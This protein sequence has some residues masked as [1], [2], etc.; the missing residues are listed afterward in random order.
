MVSCQIVT[1]SSLK[2]GT[3]RSSYDGII[4]RERRLKA[5]LLS[6]PEDQHAESKKILLMCAIDHDRSLTGKI[7]RKSTS[8]T[9]SVVAL[10]HLCRASC[11]HLATTEAESVHRPVPANACSVMPPIAVAAIPVEAVRNVLLAGSPLRMCFR[12]RDFPVPAG[13][14]RGL[15]ML[16]D[17]AESHGHVSGETPARNRKCL[18]SF[19]DHVCDLLCKLH[20]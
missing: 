16:P 8:S 10:H 12:M 3:G 14:V 7:A 19:H 17:K 13:K 5:W 11:L 20:L 6:F 18:E 2:H 4:F 1:S 15:V 9:M